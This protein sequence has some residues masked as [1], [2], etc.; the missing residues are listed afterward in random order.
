MPLLG[1]E[2]PEEHG[3]TA[4]DKDFRLH[5]RTRSEMTE[6]ADEV[7]HLPVQRAWKRVNLG[8]L[9]SS[10]GSHDPSPDAPEGCVIGVNL[11]NLFR[12]L[13]A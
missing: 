2:S 9:P 3:E 7:G 13:H 8:E 12:T 10:R 5:K 1:R 4:S 11:V 6:L